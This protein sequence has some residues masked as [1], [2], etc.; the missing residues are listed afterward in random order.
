VTLIK[1]IITRLYKLRMRISR[2]TGLGMNVLSN[3]KKASPSQ[4]F[5][6]LS[7]KANN[8]EIISFE[9]FRNKKVLLVNLASKCGYTPQ[10]NELEELHQQYKNNL[11][12][13]GFP[14]NDFGGQEPGNDKEIGEF[15]RINFGVSFPLFHKDHVKGNDKQS[16]Y[17]WLTDP[18]KNGWNDQEPSWNFCKYLVNED[19]R[20]VNVFSSAVSPTGP[21]ITNQL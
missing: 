13:I 9:R 10:Y 2:Q 6:S 3:E 15:C 7:A 8:G 14:S 4:S 16:V 12:V 17:E 20:L 5:Y 21:E 18:E 1:N 11:S 19:G